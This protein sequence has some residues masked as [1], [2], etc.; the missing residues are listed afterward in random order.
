LLGEGWRPQAGGGKCRKTGQE[1]KTTQETRCT[2]RNACTYL[3]FEGK[4]YQMFTFREFKSKLLDD[5]FLL[6]AKKKQIL[7]LELLEMLFY[8]ILS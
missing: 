3:G 6:F 4:V 7:E 5:H 8:L 2:M 1:G